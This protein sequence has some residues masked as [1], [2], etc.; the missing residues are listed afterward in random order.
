[1]GNLLYQVRL[2]MSQSVS[3]MASRMAGVPDEAAEGLKP[4]SQSGGDKWKSQNI[5]SSSKRF[6]ARKYDA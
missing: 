2:G 3:K 1:M 5:G 6:I 4:V